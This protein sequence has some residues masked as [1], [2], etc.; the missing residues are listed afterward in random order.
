MTVRRKIKK[1]YSVVQDLCECGCK[2][3]NVYLCD[4]NGKYFASFSLSEDQWFPFAEDAVRL[5]R[6]EKQ[7]GPNHQVMH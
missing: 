4:E 5:C 3:V 2:C 7:L 6:N 1:A